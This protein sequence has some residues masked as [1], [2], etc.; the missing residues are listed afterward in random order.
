M[1]LEAVLGEDRP[2]VAVLAF[3][4][5]AITALEA[6]GAAPEQVVFSTIYVVGLDADTFQAFVRGMNEALDGKPMRPV[7]QQYSLL[8]DPRACTRLF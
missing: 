3:G 2:D 4:T 5:P 6:A 8:S 7:R 1:T